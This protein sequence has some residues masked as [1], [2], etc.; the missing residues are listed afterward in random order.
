M[1]KLHK[2]KLG[3]LTVPSDL[4]AERAIRKAG[5]WGCLDGGV[6]ESIEYLR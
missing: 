4:G 2:V 5:N 6:G 3:I 1:T